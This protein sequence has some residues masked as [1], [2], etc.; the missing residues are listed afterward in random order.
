MDIKWIPSDSKR[1]R[2]TGMD[3]LRALA[4]ISVLVFHW[5][6]IFE[7][8][9]SLFLA[10]VGHLG[11]DMFFVLSGFLVSLSFLYTHSLKSYFKKRLMRII[12][13]AYFS[14]L[15]IFAAK[16]LGGI[17]PFDLL[18]IKDFLVHL[19]FTQSLFFDHYYGNFPVMWTLSV[20]LIFYF[21]VPIL[22]FFGRKSL[23]TFIGI[24]LGLLIANFS[25][26]YHL[27]Q[28]FGD[29]DAHQRIFYSEQIW[30]RF[31]QFIYGILLSIIFLFRSHLQILNRLKYIIGLFGLTLMLWAGSRFNT[32]EGA[33]R[34]V[35][36]LQV[37]LHSIFA[38]GFAFVLLW[39]IQISE[40]FGYKKIPILDYLGEISYGIYV[41][42]FFALVVSVKYI[43]N[44]Y[45]GLSI[46]FLSTIVIASFSW[47]VI[48][49]PAL[50]LVKRK[51]LK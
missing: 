48:E 11:V 13:L 17:I 31:D 7:A 16:I 25:Y 39:L 3:S 36:W 30:G 4:A 42:H 40:I 26:R 28:F 38:L 5:N 47:F 32:L 51:T 9:S 35:A 41:W 49:K 44:I 8:Y 20:E 19:S 24:L 21:L 6:G 27:I 22:F 14:L 45:L 12:P 33:F 10:K 18:S 34:T 2:I 23:K 43:E 50:K 37:F 46:S 15:I 29:W 1:V